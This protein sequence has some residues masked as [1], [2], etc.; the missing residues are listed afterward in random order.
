ARLGPTRATQAGLLT[1]RQVRAALVLC[2]SMCA[3][4][5][6]YLARIGGLPVVAIGVLSILSG[7]AY[8]GGPFPLGYHGLGDLF[9]F[10]FFGL[11]AVAGTALVQAGVVPTLAWPVGSGIGA[12][13]TSVLVVNNL[14]DC[15]T[16]VLAGK[17]T[18][19]VRFGARAVRIE[20][21]LLLLVAF[22]LLPVVA[23]LLGSALP[24]VALVVLRIS[25]RLI[26]RVFTHEGRA[27]NEDL[28]D[29]ARLLLVYGAALAVGISFANVRG[30]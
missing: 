23:R 6:V 12:L 13:A 1:P 24:L 19:A 8:T 20:F 21:A 15:D 16:D 26:W 7:L 10:V 14:R 9:V 11:V 30:A 28:T 4:F 25:I 27:L 18:I 5:G 29:T 17:R 2:I 22:A 3:P